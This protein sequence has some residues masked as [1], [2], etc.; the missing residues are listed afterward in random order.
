MRIDKFVDGLTAFGE[1]LFLVG[2]E[3]HVPLDSVQGGVTDA[4]DNGVGRFPD[5]CLGNFGF[6]ASC[7]KFDCSLDLSCLI[8]MRLRHY[9]ELQPVPKLGL[10]K[11]PL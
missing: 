10:L 5:N 8:L 7:Q 4:L 6:M 3:L 9:F 2:R 1:N 11:R